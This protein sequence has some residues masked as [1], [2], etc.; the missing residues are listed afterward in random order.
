MHEPTDDNGSL[1]QRAEKRLHDVPESLDTLSREEAQRLLHELHVHQVELEMQNTELRQAQEELTAARDRYL[2]LYDFAP[3]GYLTISVDGHILHANLTSASLLGVARHDLVHQPLSRFIARDGQEGYHF[4]RQRLGQNDAPQTVDLPLVKADGMMFWARLDAVVASETLITG[5]QETPVYRMTITNITDRKL[6]EETSAHQAAE[7][8][9]TLASLADGLVV[10]NPDGDIVRMN[11][12]ALH[13]L[14]Y[15]PDLPAM[16]FAEHLRALQVEA[17]DGNVYSPE[18]LPTARA[19]RGDTTQGAVMVLH[20]PDRTVWVLASAAPIR[21]PDGQQ[22]GAVTTFSDITP[23]HD[24]QEQQLLL[25]LV[26]H[27]LRTPLAVISGYTSVIADKVK[28]LG[29]DDTITTSLSAIQ[30]GVKWMMV[31]IED[32]TELARIEGGQ[33]QLKRE[34]VEMAAYLQDFLQRSAFVLDVAR[35]QLDI[36]AEV[37]PVLAD[38]DRLDRIVSNLLSNA[39]KYSDPGTPVQICVRR[40]ED[41]VLL[42]ITDHGRG[43]PPDD[44]SHLFQRFYRAK[45][46]RRAEGIGLGL[47]ITK[48]LVE[49]HGGRIWVE[50][51]V[52]KGSTFSFTLPIA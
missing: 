41:E 14:A 16:P 43:I 40:Q 6:A 38:Y 21:M 4:L 33:L 29:V 49:A 36:A 22:L 5:G 37:P 26:S 51:D 12:A 1:R 42:S 9:A 48:Q 18:K 20:H 35:I 15:T 24:L 2:D 32:L 25:H 46:E 34:P 27:D 7:L 30:R 3:V 19:L 17:L 50:S 47:Y 44:V 39:L 45:G 52:G 31:M 23:L 13:L 8:T 10:F 11:D 28:E